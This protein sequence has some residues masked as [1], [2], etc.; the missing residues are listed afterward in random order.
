[1]RGQT[2][3]NERSDKRKCLKTNTTTR[4]ISHEMALVVDK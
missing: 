3:E 4:A 1:M 2:R